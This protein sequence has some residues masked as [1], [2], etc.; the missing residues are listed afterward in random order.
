MFLWDGGRGC[1]A[2][3]PAR[4]VRRARPKLRAAADPFDRVDPA[5][6]IKSTW[7]YDDVRAGEAIAAAGGG[8]SRTVAV[9]DTGIDVNHPEFGGGSARIA[10]TFDTNTGS[11]SVPDAIGHGTF[12][13]GLI[14]AIDGNGIGAKGV[15]GNTRVMA[16]RAS[17]DGFFEASDLIGGIAFAIRN[18]ADVL[19]MSL[20]GRGISLSQARAL[21]AAFYNDVLPVAAS[22][23]R[24]SW[25]T[26]SSFLPRRWAA[27][28]AARVSAC[29][30][31]PRTQRR[32]RALLEPQPLRLPGGAGRRPERVPVRRFSTLP[33]NLGTAWDGSCSGIFV[34]GAARWLRGG[35]RASRLPSRRASP[36]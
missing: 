3:R 20:A 12:V 24:A 23:N 33:A 18:R 15:A 28:A 14:A 32:G 29:R 31:L 21:R 4:G 8:S 10:R 16:V 6:G 19:N 36:R 7:F 27:C 2:P 11:T 30:W 26:R 5:T 34:A 13:G 35:A 22:G 9:I 1:P 25:A 17:R